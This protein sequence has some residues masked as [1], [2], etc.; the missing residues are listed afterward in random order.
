MSRRADGGRA[1]AWHPGAAGS[2]G[3]EPGRCRIT[4]QAIMSVSQPSLD[5]GSPVRVPRDGRV[6]RPALT[7]D[8]LMAV[9]RAELLA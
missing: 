5:N 2:A 4:P 8:D 1:G 3:G 9:K 6:A 7:L